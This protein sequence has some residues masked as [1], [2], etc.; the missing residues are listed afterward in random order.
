MGP[1]SGHWSV[2]VAHPDTP[3]GASVSITVEA[4]R[5]A[6]GML[7]CDYALHA[8]LRRVRLPASRGGKRTD[9]LW[10]HTCFEAFVS[11]ADFGGYCEFN[12]SPALDW[13]AYS[14]QEYRGGMTPATLV[15]SPALHVHAGSNRLELSATVDLA[16]LA[17][18]TGAT[19]LR[20]GLAA[21]LESEAG[22][23]SYWSLQHAPGRPDFHHP[24]SFSLELSSP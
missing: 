7:V 6:P 9:Q 12:F 17:E 22:E 1:E 2:L 4:R 21:V 10:R 8:D 20:L 14:F 18:L 19:R 23:L 16:G 24:D 3:S 15:Q 11:A 13:A 5:T